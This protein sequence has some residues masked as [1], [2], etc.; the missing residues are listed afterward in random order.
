MREVRI[1]K[2]D[3]IIVVTSNLLRIL[4]EQT[5]QESAPH[6]TVVIHVHHVKRK[7][8]EIRHSL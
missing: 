2:M 3:L 5:S 6:A 4:S 8:Y 7:G 1:V